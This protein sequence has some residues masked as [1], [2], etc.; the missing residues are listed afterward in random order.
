METLGAP[1]DTLA[2]MEKVTGIGGIFFRAKDPKALRHWYQRHLGVT[3][4][5][6]SYEQLQWWPEA[7]VTTVEPFPDD[8]SYFGTAWMINF[9]VRDLVAMVTQLQAAGV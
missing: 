1:S 5:P 4:T 8:T 2:T 9:W 7:G 3:V 6:A